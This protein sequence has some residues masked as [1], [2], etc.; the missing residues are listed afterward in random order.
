MQNK[1]EHLLTGGEILINHFSQDAHGS[2]ATY[3]QHDD[4]DGKNLRYFSNYFMSEVDKN[5]LESLK[6]REIQFKV[7]S[8]TQKGYLAILPDGREINSTM[9]SFDKNHPELVKHNLSYLLFPTKE[10]AIKLLKN[11]EVVVKYEPQ[12]ENKIKKNKP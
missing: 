3:W 8:L 9:V 4:K 11:E 12:E 1:T 2:S 5:Y 10:I 7:D 6:N